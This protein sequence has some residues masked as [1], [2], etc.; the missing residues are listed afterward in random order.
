M[1]LETLDWDDELLGFFGIPAPD[2]ARDPCRPPTP[3]Q[4]RHAPAPRPFGGE[5]PIAGVLGDQQAATVGQVCFTTG[6]A[7]NTYG[8]GNFLLLNTG[9]EIVRSE[10]G[11]LTT[12]GYQLGD[13][14]AVRPRGLDRRHRLGGPVAARPARHHLQR[15]ARSRRW[16]RRSTTPAA[17]YFVPAFSGLFAPYWRSDARGAIVGLSRFNTNAHL[18]R[19]TLEAIC[20][21]SRDVVE[22]M[23]ADAGA[24]PGRAQGRR[25]R[26]RERALHAA[27]GRRPR[28]RRSA[29]RWSP[30][31]PR[32]APA[33]AAGPGRRLLGHRRR[34]A[35]RTGTRT[36]AGRRRSS[37]DDAQ[38]GYAGWQKA[39][40]A[41]PGL[42]RGVKEQLGDDHTDHSAHAGHGAGPGPQ[43]RAGAGPRDRGRRDQLLALPRLRRQEPGRRRRGR[44]D[45]PGARRGPDERRR[46]HRRGREGRGADALQRRAGRRRLRPRVGHRR[47]PGRRHHLDRQEPARRGQRARRLATRDHVQ[48]RSGRLHAQAGRARCRGL[49]GRPRRPDR[50]HAEQDREAHR[51]AAGSS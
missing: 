26:H 8:T 15:R 35:R 18:A 51:P 14:P 44:R 32:S 43:P 50:R 30:R 20:Y 13:D 12:V 22:A 7:K 40:A 27:P 3:Q 46:G 42:G 2:A 37:E 45:A 23:E 19:A 6:E 11:L 36:A 28:R 48:P 49:G 31:R 25:R 24:E 4:L 17:L 38:A 41:H 29:S 34:A 33:Y 5:V 21:Q 16:P 9:T 10:H 39:V 1:D 47:R